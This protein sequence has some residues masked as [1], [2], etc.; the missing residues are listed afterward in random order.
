ML[1]DKG[2]EVEV[3]SVKH[4]C[5]GSCPYDGEYTEHRDE[6]FVT[7][8][9]ILTVRIEQHYDKQLYDEF[10]NRLKR[11][12]RVRDWLQQRANKQFETEQQELRARIDGTMS[13][14]DADLAAL[15]VADHHYRQYRPKS[16][17]DMRQFYRDMSDALEFKTLAKEAEAGTSVPY[18]TL[19]GMHPDCLK[20]HFSCAEQR[21]LLNVARYRSLA[22]FG[23]FSFGIPAPEFV[24]LLEQ[25]PRTKH[26]AARI[27]PYKSLLA[28]KEVQLHFGK[29]QPE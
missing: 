13:P 15:T 20:A 17:E 23:T 19:Q 8:P 27:A 9:D 11:Y 22:L 7:T 14:K 28:D 21:N 16:V 12:E 2:L 26:Y 10:E 18:R 1:C 29:Y 24:A 3:R 25:S 6:G 4:V 5:R